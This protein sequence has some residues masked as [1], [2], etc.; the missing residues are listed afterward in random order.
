MRKAP[1]SPEI[2]QGDG[3]TLF[4]YRVRL[5]DRG[6]L[7][8]LFLKPGRL[9]LRRAASKWSPMMQAAINEDIAAASS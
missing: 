5:V 1:I 8:M 4:C 3:G 7:P 2:P 6:R 9:L